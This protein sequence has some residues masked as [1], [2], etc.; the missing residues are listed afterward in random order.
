MGGHPRRD[1]AVTLLSE[2]VGNSVLHTAS[3]VIGIVVLVERDGDLM[4]EVIDE[5][6]GT[7]PS[8]AAGAGDPL[9][10]S[11][12][13]IRMI[14]ALAARWGFVEE[15]PHC[16]LWF[17]LSPYAEA[18]PPSADPPLNGCPGGR[19]DEEQRGQA[20]TAHAD[21]LWTTRAPGKAVPRYGRGVLN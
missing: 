1:D 4:I 19:G 16:L 9:S 2:A 15:S 10:E 18:D 12:R 20:S 14:R 17:V 6:S 8:V 5:G 11:G 21:R 7:V 13:G 3:A